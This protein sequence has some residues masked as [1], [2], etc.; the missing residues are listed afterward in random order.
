M[1]V[2]LSPVGGVAAQFFTNSG[3]VLTG[4]KLYTYAAGTT[5]PAATYTSS[6]GNT[7]QPNPIVLDA[8]GRV[9][10]SGEIWLTDGVNY[11]F[12]LKDA[13]DVLIATYDNVSGINSNFIAFTNSQ[14]IFTATSGQTV[15]TLANA[16]QPGT[17]SLSVF[18]DGV[19]QYGSGAQYAYVETDSTTVTFNAGLHVGAEVKFTTTQQ[20]GAGAV[21]ASQVT[22]DPPFTGSV[23]TNV[24]AKL[25]QTVSVKDFGAVGDGVTDDTAAFATALVAHD[26]IY[27]PAGTY[28]VTGITMSSKKVLFGDGEESVINCSG[29]IDFTDARKGGLRH[30]RVNL[31]SASTTLI[32][33]QKGG[34][35]GSF[36]LYF[37]DVNFVG[38]ISNASTVG[39]HIT[40]SY[41]N[42]FVNCLFIDF[43][44]AIIHGV[45]ANRN[46]YFGCS[47]RAR[48]TYGTALI[49]QTAGQ[50]NSFVGCDVENCNQMLV[51]SGGSIFFGEG[52]YFEAHNAS[53]GFDL[54]GGHVGISHSYFNETFLRVQSGGSL[55]LSK[56]W[57]KA[58]SLSNATYPVIRLQSGYAALILDNNIR[59]GA[60]FLCRMNPTRYDYVQVYDT[61]TST[62]VNEH[63]STNQLSINDVIYDV[64]TASTYQIRLDNA[65]QSRSRASIYT[66][67][68]VRFDAGSNGVQLVSS[69]WNY[70]PLRLGA[71]YL[72]V[73]STGDL[74]IKNGAPTSDTDGTVVG[75]QT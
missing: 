54:T 69:A 53:F 26:N 58:S 67:G 52:C 21:D 43:D 29:T 7:A 11:K 20:Q 31:T 49:E 50:A 56:N 16:Y 38:N 28:A 48:T 25:A 71:Y 22:Y 57:I 74:R 73:D 63:P 37:E 18:V 60:T 41:I 66:E 12:V 13:N 42:T 75:T 46:N 33:L 10:N 59:Q 51:L 47:I 34:G 35:V 1:A 23:V 55:E 27:V 4:G 8:A 44:K 2:N 32:R 36:E 6:S 40:D 72:W 45:E 62:W 17:N 39:I 9:P 14:E 24:E 61:G 19:N 65:R 3:A 70:N 30:L 64:D 68:R 5:T 15:F